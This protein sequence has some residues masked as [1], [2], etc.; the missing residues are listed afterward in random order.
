MELINKCVNK[1]LFSKLIFSYNI[2]MINCIAQNFKSRNNS[3][4]NYDEIPKINN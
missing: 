2:A 1:K 4:E 3:Y